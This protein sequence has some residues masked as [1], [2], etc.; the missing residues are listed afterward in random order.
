MAID[1]LLTDQEKDGSW[2]D[3]FDVREIDRDGSPEEGLKE[4]TYENVVVGERFGPVVLPLTPYRALRYDF[5]MGGVNALADETGVSGRPLAHPGSFSNELFEIYTIDYSASAIVGLH[6]SEEIW[7]ER[8]AEIGDELTLEGEFVDKYEKRGQ[9]YAV[10]R[11]EARD[12]EGR[13]VARRLGTEIMRTVPGN[14]VGRK[15]AGKSEKRIDTT[16]DRSGRR[17]EAGSRELLPGDWFELEPR[18]VTFEQAAL[19]SRFGEY[20]TSI[21]GSLDAA[22]AAGLAVPIVQGQQ[23]M[24]LLID[25]LLALIG[26]QFHAGGHV[27]AKFISPV[28]V[29]SE[30][31]FQGRVVEEADDPAAV[32]IECWLSDETGRTVTVANVDWR[33]K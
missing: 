27:A 3:L 33:E 18:L 21:H 23:Q 6:A 29:F 28:R 24:C 20:V 26:P 14:V 7:L 15:A 16:L 25:S 13:L 8:P 1:A 17:V 10:V 32:R 30:L 22:R 12:Q 19:Y 2:H 9:G 5:I 31:S 4:P 11:A